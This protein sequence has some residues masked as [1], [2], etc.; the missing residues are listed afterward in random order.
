MYHRVPNSI[1]RYSD[2]IVKTGLRVERKFKPQ[3]DKSKRDTDVWIY[4]HYTSK[5]KKF[6]GITDKIKKKF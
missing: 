3:L 6:M 2:P 4:K 1:K 5:V